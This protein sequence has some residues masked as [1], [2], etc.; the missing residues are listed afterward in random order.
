ML[1]VLTKRP[2]FSIASILPRPELAQFPFE[3]GI[4]RLKYKPDLF[5]FSVQSESLA[6][7]QSPHVQSLSWEECCESRALALLKLDKEKYYLSFSGGIDSTS[8]LVSLLRF[9][10][11]QDHKRIRVLMTET[12]ILENPAFFDRHVCKLEFVHSQAQ[13]ACKL[14]DKNSI[15]LTGELGD[16]L[17]GS[18]IL[19]EA[20]DL[21][22]EDCLKGSYKEYAPKLIEKRGGSRG[23]GRSIFENLEPIVEECPFPVRTLHDFFWWFNF[24]QKWQYVKFRHLESREWDLSKRYGSHVFHFFDTPEFQRWSLENHDRKI[25]KTWES[26][27]FTA[28]DYIYSFTKNSDDLHLKKVQSLKRTYLF[29]SLR[30]GID[31]DYNA[32]LTLEDLKPHVRQ[33][34]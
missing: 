24:T 30:T 12:S 13:P 29:N 31:V 6:E 18:D 7:I 20:C 25:Q 26:Y 14:L 21:F 17:F 9:W 10:P 11:T 34:N 19:S 4:S 8:A 5:N 23:H 2:R 22:G 3:S 28:K 15:L 16:Q 33:K 32:L 27:K 1:L